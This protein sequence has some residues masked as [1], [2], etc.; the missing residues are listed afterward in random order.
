MSRF[1]HPALVFILA[2]CLLVAGITTL[3]WAFGS[4]ISVW[5]TA[6]F[7]VIGGITALL[8]DNLGRYLGKKRHTLFHLRPRH[9]ATLLTFLAGFLIPLITVSLLWALSGDVRLI[10]QKGA[11]LNAD[12]QKGQ[13][14]LATLRTDLDN[15]TKEISG[16]EQQRTK[17]A[18]D[19]DRASK[20]LAERK[21]DIAKLLNDAREARTQITQ[22]RNQLGD[23]RGKLGSLQTDYKNLQTK[24][25]DA[26][27]SF[28]TQQK[29]L[30]DV[31]QRQTQLDLELQRLEREIVASQGRVK[32][33][34][35]RER[36]A[37]EELKK[38]SEE[39]DAL[40]ESFE[41]ERIRSQR[42][43]E[44]A[45]IDLDAVKGE[46]NNLVQ[47]SQSLR[48]NLDY[49]R[50]R[51]MIFSIGE[52]IARASVPARATEAQAGGILN[53]L[54][55]A[56]KTEAQRRGADPEG[57]QGIAGLRELRV[58]NNLLSAEVQMERL[59][60]EIT[61]KPE[62]T[63]IVA[64]ALW[65]SYTGE[66]VPIRIQ[67]YANPVVYR[68]GQL[69]AEARIDGTL[70]EEG[71]LNQLTNFLTVDVV[72]KA[73]RDR[74]IPATGRDA[75]FGAISS[76]DVLQLVR[77]IK[78]VGRMI[79]VQAIAA[80]DTRAADPLKLDFRLR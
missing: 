55:R 64:Y 67:S 19:L 53:S 33:L 43:L 30:N 50:T 80:S 21:A 66:F 9:T 8:A 16:L 3:R 6:L 61:G 18:A 39:Y 24:L 14:E 10:L 70:T 31:N 59:Q 37:R 54:I 79:R 45:R 62:G 76:E 71:I 48:L 60:A 12:L 49:A 35:E 23:L 40:Q 34:Q 47:I 27:T 56:V 42:E 17:A 28:N 32:E 46:V 75:Q 29:L 36:N 58:D 51:P 52:E 74:M 2:G 25:S 77:D 65:N 44:A 26:N 63:A 20:Q 69:V 15:R 78:S 5:F 13:R 57:K 73:K 4:W 11:Q 7:C 41:N 38:T 68:Q 1:S 22:Y 72:N